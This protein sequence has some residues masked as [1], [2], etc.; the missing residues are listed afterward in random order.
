MEDERKSHI[1]Y[2]ILYAV[3]NLLIGFIS[4]VLIYTSPNNER[5]VYLFILVAFI[6]LLYFVFLKNH[7]AFFIYPY[8]LLLAIYISIVIENI[9]LGLKYGFE[10][11]SSVFSLS[12]EIF[13]PVLIIILLNALSLI[14]TKVTLYFILK[15]KNKKTE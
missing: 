4:F 9:I 14:L 15:H 7:L 11:T 3:F 2:C 5:S 10:V 13:A 1:L 12:I 6:S 8:F